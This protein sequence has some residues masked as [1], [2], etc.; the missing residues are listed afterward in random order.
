MIPQDARG[1]HD[2]AFKFADEMAE[3]EQ[4]IESLPN[5]F[6]HYSRGQNKE[7]VPPFKFK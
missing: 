6:S 4:Y 1:K 5:Y 3:I 2:C 7:N